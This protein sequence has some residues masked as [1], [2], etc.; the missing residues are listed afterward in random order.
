MSDLSGGDPTY[1]YQKKKDNIWYMVHLSLAV[2]V[3]IISI[4]A[5]HSGTSLMARPTRPMGCCSQHQHTF[6]PESGEGTLVYAKVRRVFPE[7]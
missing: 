3:D 5:I 1:A 2:G 6:G 7:A 4:L